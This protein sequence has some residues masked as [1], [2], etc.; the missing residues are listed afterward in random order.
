M[1]IKLILSL[2]AAAGLLHVSGADA[3]FI[4]NKG[5]WSANIKYLAKSKN[6]YAWVTDS[7]VVYDHFQLYTDSAD[8]D[9]MRIKGSVLAMQLQNTNGNCNHIG[10]GRQGTHHNYFIGSDRTAWASQVPLY[11]KVIAKNIYD[12]ID[13]CYYFDSS[14]KSRI[15]Y[16][17]ELQPNADPDAIRFRINGASNIYINSIGEL[18]I[19]TDNGIFRHKELF[20]FQSMQD[21]Y[22]NK[23]INNRQINCR[24]VKHADNT[25]GFELGKYDKSKPLTIDPLIYSVLIG[26]VDAEYGYAITV[27]TLGCAYIAGEVHSQHFPTT[28][29]AYDR[30]F[31][32]G[33]QQSDASSM[34]AFISK[35]DNTGKNILFSTF[36]GGSKRDRAKYIAL[37]DSMNIVVV[38]ET[39]SQDTAY[40]HTGFPIETTSDTLNRYN[41]GW[42]VFVAKFNNS[43]NQLIFSA[44]IGGDAY[45]VSG[46]LKID[47]QNTIWVAGET[48][49]AQKIFPTTPNAY[50]K[51]FAG[52]ESDCFVSRINTMGSHLLYSSLFGGN[53][54][55]MPVSI[56]VDTASNV[57]IAGNTASSNFPITP[58]AFQQ[59]MQGTGDIFVTKFDSTLSYLIYSTYIGGTKDEY[60]A[61]I[62]IDDNNCAYISGYSISNNFPTTANTYSQTQSDSAD[63]VVFKLDQTAQNLLLS[64]TI[65]SNNRNYATGIAIDKLK[66]IHISGYTHSTNYPATW[67]AFFDTYS[68]FG[69]MV[70]SVFDT[71]LSNLLYSSYIG[72]R[73]YDY[74]YGLALDKIDAAYLVGATTS[75]YYFPHSKVVSDSIWSNNTWQTLGSYD[76]VVFK[77][78]EKPY[79]GELLTNIN[80]LG[81]E[82]CPGVPVSITIYTPHA[83]YFADNTFYVQMSDAN[84][85]FA[86]PIVIG[87]LQ[88]ST[89]GSTTI[90]FPA[91][92]PVGYGYRIRVV[93][94]KP[95]SIGEDN[96][97]DLTIRG[98]YMSLNTLALT[99]YCAGNTITAAYETNSC[100]NSGNIF[101]LEMS[102]D[103]GGSFANPVVIASKAGVS[104]D[105]ISGVIPSNII[106]I[107][108]NYSLR[109][110][111]S[112]PAFISDTQTMSIA[113]PH[114]EVA[115]IAEYAFCAEESFALPYTA[116]HCFA[117]SN[118]FYALL[119]DVTGSFSS[120][121]DTIGYAMSNHSGTIP[122]TV[123]GN[124]ANGDKYR[125]RI[126]STQPEAYAETA[127]SIRFILG[128][129]YIY[130][131][132]I[133]GME[134]CKGF[135]FEITVHASNCFDY[136][137]KFI[138]Q[139]KIDSLWQTIGETAYNDSVAIITIPD[140]SGIS[141]GA[142]VLRILST[143][144]EIS[145]PDI[146]V[147]VT[148]PTMQVHISQAN[149]ICRNRNVEVAY[150]SN[151]CFKQGTI[152]Y[153][154]LSDTG[155]VF[156]SAPTIIGTGIY[157]I[158]HENGILTANIPLNIPTSN[159]YKIRIMTSD[160]LYTNEVAVRI[161]D[162]EASI[163]ADISDMTVLCSGISFYVNYTANGCFNEGNVFT[164]ELSDENGNFSTTSSVIIGSIASATSGKILVNIPLGMKN[165]SKYRMLLASSTPAKKSIL[166]VDFTIEQPSI[167]ID[168]L[169]NFN[170][171][172][173]IDENKNKIYAM[174]TQVTVPFAASDCFGQP[175]IFI[176]QLA[177]N[178]DFSKAAN[179]DTCAW[180]ERQFVF[181]FPANIENVPYRM[182]VISTYPELASAD[183]GIDIKFA[184]P[185]ITFAGIVKSVICKGN[186]NTFEYYSTACFNADNVFYLEIS[187][188]N[189]GFGYS[190]IIAYSMQLGYGTFNAILPD[191]MLAGNGYKL[192]IRSTSPSI[193]YY[194]DKLYFTVS[195]PEILTG[196]LRTLNL[197]RNDTISVPFNTN[198]FDPTDIAFYVQLSDP[199]GNFNN[200]MEIGGQTGWQ[201]DGE[202]LTRIPL[203]A[204]DGIKYRMRVISK[205]PA[206]TGND[207]SRDI[208]IR[209]T[210]SIDEL[211]DNTEL[212]VYPDIAVDVI[213]IVNK[214][215]QKLIF[216]ELSDITGNQLFHSHDIGFVQ[217]YKIDVSALPSGVYVL[218]ICTASTTYRYPILKL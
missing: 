50:R 35:L 47:R 206:L 115:G 61:G 86:N 185:E 88:A 212:M 205:T 137:N 10:I 138:I 70:Y 3:A 68:D 151:G 43:G 143:N 215:E 98:A 211:A 119:S 147:T 103:T 91:N 193:I 62:A 144:P 203:K 33:Y 208:S 78:T 89:G 157:D 123:P 149:T 217:N 71:S 84:G 132:N 29:G 36:L 45:D 100:F 116:N 66:K 146:S 142:N 169:K 130:T 182:R 152:L 175:N 161:I 42:D 200:P 64:T 23:F 121:I 207:N 183:N 177:P 17:F 178:G 87:Q 129:P 55:D 46:G 150:T 80:L 59:S 159:K 131:D 173:Q 12:G 108:G 113:L 136:E 112:S 37:D 134:L 176:L 7:G 11:N 2:L 122:C 93:S 54:R 216:I 1:K 16:D 118:I 44:L 34:D 195:S 57:Y 99:A 109:L 120:K 180:N 39:E 6:I 85:S 90:I 188:M 128:S 18:V 192:R 77:A 197:S 198:C 117:D 114:I 160:S 26:S 187:D 56:G 124:V 79:P 209:G 24:F 31:N 21:D 72:G 202:I 145:T 111:S 163:D 25:I 102:S 194:D 82:F 96:G 140:I 210:G 20:A 162:A 22:E 135:A 189:G 105:S 49:M 75:G 153:I 92:T 110:T 74:A 67:D 104:S 218:T 214:N 127:D 48:R 141:D 30:Y 191:E 156:G 52:G 14:E 155:G 125:I 139:I 19:E 83:F 58:N 190:Q 181:A 69:D 201:D 9:K 179:L 186:I 166:D 170:I 213:D 94:T 126:A 28:S 51:T 65:S 32:D 81:S 204:S 41:G 13:I 168:S 199:K 15:R 107:A 167:V 133:S 101:K 97:T 60:P 171:C 174:N 184:Q 53:G 106:K 8:A 63:I 76:V 40:P 148:S 165:G 5:Q 73:Y 154:Q 158:S 38:G 164:I 95:R 196:N 4:E 172:V 27:D